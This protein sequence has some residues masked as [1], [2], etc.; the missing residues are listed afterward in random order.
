MY[1]FSI[2]KLPGMLTAILSKLR[3][4]IRITLERP[5]LIISMWIFVAPI[6]D[7]NHAPIVVQSFGI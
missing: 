6:A 2:S 1:K 7:K 5:Q 4:H 3:I